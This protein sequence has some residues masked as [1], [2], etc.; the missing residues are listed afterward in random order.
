MKINYTSGY[1]CDSLT[2]DGIESFD[3]PAEDIKEAIVLSLNKVED[4]AALQNILISVLE[5]AGEFEDL[6]HCE[7]CGDFIYS[8]TLET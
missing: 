2:I 4:I 7:Q 8:Y 6:G 3:M 5:E 1:T